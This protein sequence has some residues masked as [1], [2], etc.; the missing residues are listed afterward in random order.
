MDGNANTLSETHDVCKVI[1]SEL[2]HGRD[3]LLRV[4][5]LEV[6]IGTEFTEQS[7]EHV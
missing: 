4:L 6:L 2:A 3:G 5:L 1:K 7:E